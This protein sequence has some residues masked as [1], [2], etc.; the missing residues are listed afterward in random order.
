[1]LLS[2][3]PLS[4]IYL[5]LLVNFPSHWKLEMFYYFIESEG[6]PKED[7][8]LLWYSGGPGCSAF[9]GLIYEIGPLEFNISDYEGGLP[10]L[11]YY[12]YSWTKTASILFVDAPVGTGFS[13][14]TTAEG[15][16][17]S[18]T[19]TGVQVYEFL[20]KWLIDHPQYLKLE[21]FVGADS[22]SGIS[23]TL[24]IQNILDG[25]GYGREPH[26]NLKGYILGCPR[27]DGQIQEN[28][29]II[30]AHRMALISDEL[31]KAT[32]NAC[33]SD[34][35]GVTSSDA[36][37]YENLQLIKK[38]I[39]DINKNDIL[40][41]KCT[42]A[43]PDPVEESTRRSLRGNSADFIKS[44]VTI[45]E[46]WCHNLNY[47]LSYVWANDES[48]QA[49]L[50][51]SQQ[52]IKELDLTIVNDW[53]PWLVDGQVAGYT[54]KYSE[55][56][57]RLTEQATH[58]KNTSV[59]NVMTCLI[60]EMADVQL[61]YY[62]FESE[63]DPVFDPLLLW[64]TGGPGCSGFSAIAFEN[65]PL[66]IDRDTYS[67]GLP[68]LKYNPYS[69]TKIASIIF[70]DAPVGTGFSYATTTEAANTSDTLSA[71]QTYNFLRKW[72]VS[73]PKFLGNQ[74]Y[75]GGDSYSGIIVPLLV[76]DILQGIE[77]GLK[78]SI[79]LQ[80]YLLG[81]PVTDYY[82]DDNSRIPFIHRVSLISDEYYEDAKLY[83]MSILQLKLTQIL[84]PQ[85]AFSSKKPGELEWDI[86]SQEANVI[87]SLQANKLPE[88]R[89]REFGYALSY[90]YMNNE[91]VQSA[92]VV[93]E[94]TVKTW[95]SGDHDISVP[96][97]GTLEWIRSLEIAV[98]DE[99]RPWYV[100]GQVAGYQTKF[101][102][103]HF[104]L[105]YVT[106]KGGG[107]TAPE[108]KPKECQAMVDSVV[109]SQS[110]IKTLP[111]FDGDLPFTLET[112]YIGV[113]EMDEV[114]L[115]YYFI[116]SER[117]PR[118]DPLVLWLTGGPGCSALSA[119]FYEIGPITF[120]YSNFSWETLPTL[121]L[122]PY[123]W[124]KWLMGHP[125]FVFHPLY[126]GG[127]SYSGITV[128]MLVQR[129]SNGIEAGDKPLNNIKGFFLGNPFTD[130]NIDINARL[131]FAH[132]N[133][134]LSDELY[135]STIRDCKGEYYTPPDPSNAACVADLE[136]V[137]Y[138]LDKIYSPNILEPDCVTYISPKPNISAWNIATSLLENNF[139]HLL[140]SI[141]KISESWCR[142]DNYVLSYI[143][144]NDKNAQAALHVRE[145]TVKDW[146]RCNTSLMDIYYK[147]EINSSLL[148]QKNL[149]KKGYQALIYSGDIDM[150]VPY[151]GTQEWIKSL[152]LTI[153][154]EW[155]PWFVDGQVA[156]YVTTYSKNKY[157]LT[158]ATV[159]GAGHTA[160]EYKPEQCLAMVD[161]VKSQSIIKT[162]PGFD[163]DLPFNLET[164][165][166]GV[167]YKDEVQ[168]FYY[169]FESERNPKDDPLVL[170]LT[171]GPGCS[172]LS[173]I[174]YQ[175]GP[176]TF[177]YANSSGSIPKLMLNPHSWTKWL[178]AH[179]KFLSNPFYVGS[180]SYGGI[181]APIIVQKIFHGNDKGNKPP[182]NLKGC[183]LGNPL[184]DFKYDLNSRIE[185]AHQK[186][187]I[188]DKLYEST[189]KNCK[190]EYINPDRSKEICI[191]NLQAVNKSF[192]NLYM[193]NILEPECTTWDL[194]SFMGENDI[195][196]IMKNLDVLTK[197]QHSKRW[198]RDYMLLYSHIWANNKNVRSAL[199]VRE[200]TIKE[201]PRCNL[202]MWYEIDV[203]SS[204]EYQTMLTKR[205]YR[206]LI[207]SGDHD[208][209]I[210]YL[211]TLAWIQS[212]NLTVTEDWLPWSVDDQIAGEEVTQLQN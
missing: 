20:K 79:D 190:G 75:I 189:K 140:I 51:V 148:Y 168:L 66:A 76:Q 84:E 109:A 194:S 164:G 160:P 16:A 94:G 177:N 137:K 166:V 78:P 98:F 167:G 4:S 142:I 60:G 12:P 58:L 25:N 181:I 110:I 117:N 174:T 161:R 204:L 47:S 175:N 128:P 195:F 18:D 118:L 49:A 135:E 48:V 125:K 184:T 72:L 172:V 61:F 70:I 36:A 173:A 152:N 69:W 24:A 196:T 146:Q 209:A 141:R 17:V 21:L 210:P 103:E 149:T 198:C 182:V 3:A 41:P 9:N 133:A 186:E 73:H 157:S 132:R 31:Y 56:G 74:V 126:I 193:F 206:V 97:V 150:A 83:C 138:C 19:T 67:G 104:R 65:G 156:G 124:T 151:V 57:Y 86:R 199:H 46:K 99:W 185:Y 143:W 29:K 114:Q 43:S 37:C 139:I 96:Y 165:Y 200:G 95:N 30:Y 153:E 120:N 155:H 2:P 134:L 68:S 136:A 162:L 89:C 201:W 163:G 100:D 197:S 123:S 10:S 54:I 145:G 127:D 13:Y 180:D 176:L 192:E 85:C 33:N 39:K 55:N 52:W 179:P 45:P 5:D 108:Y 154:D 169:F 112:G 62:F 27:I 205:G 7:P 91:T 147:Y 11:S 23:A 8:L 88:L 211:G 188:S 131:T 122:N 101:M 15:W 130:E 22:Y 53:R 183:I 144:A 42:Y 82:I 111:G 115:F 187:L 40:E 113:G 170:W 92:L 102:N 107:H 77:S 90:K 14:S 38:C 119:I 44:P 81:N 87:D 6:N 34:Y 207:Y 116:E 191:S 105:T 26:L 64:L 202:S 212:L 59:G 50:N 203:R 28:S 1:M 121:T 129:I 71:S 32:K 80:G 63:R 171:G 106:V 35:Y 208:L 178:M 93:Q 159:K 158:Y